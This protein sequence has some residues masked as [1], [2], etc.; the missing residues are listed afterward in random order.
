MPVHDWTRVEAGIFHAFHHRWI[1]A[2]SDALNE[3]A[4][5]PDYYALPEQHAAGFGPDVLT[6]QGSRDEEREGDDA[7]AGEAAG[8]LVATPTLAVTAETDL[9][10]YRRKQAA[11]AVRHV[12]GDRIVAILEIVSPGN[13]AS[14]HALR[15]FVEK[16]AELLERR[17][18]LL[19]VDILPP[20]R[21]DPHGI[22]AA[23]WDEIAGQDYVPPAGR[24]LTV[25]AYEAALT[26]KAYVRPFAVGEA[27]PDM[28]LFLAPNACVPV[29]L[30]PTYEAAFAHMPRRWRQV[31]EAPARV[32]GP[33]PSP[34]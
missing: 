28:P 34:G 19:I 16:A 29:P 8:P 11:V 27:P 32:N 12:S 6:L 4:L 24:P 13:K 3:G 22:H 2:L 17:I 33:P 10:F 5:P 14:R 20:G 18:H 30:G 23:V 7:P 1:T 21:R 9:E 26:V 31:L 15:K 25:A